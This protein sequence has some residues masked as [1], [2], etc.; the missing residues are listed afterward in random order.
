MRSVVILIVIA[1]N[2]VSERIRQDGDDTVYLVDFNSNG[3][4]TYLEDVP[5]YKKLPKALQQPGLILINN[6]L[7]NH[8]AKTDGIYFRPE[9]GQPI[10]PPTADVSSLTVYWFSFY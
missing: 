8:E 6:P 3:R 5:E 4:P 9:N 2:V 7:K 10:N 1:T